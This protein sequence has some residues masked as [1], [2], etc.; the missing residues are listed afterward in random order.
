[1]KDTLHA[2]PRHPCQGS[3]HNTGRGSTCTDSA[4]PSGTRFPISSKGAHRAPC[5]CCVRA[6]RKVFCADF[7][8]LPSQVITVVCQP[9]DCSVS[10]QSK[11]SQNEST[12]A[13]FPSNNA[14]LLPKSAV[15]ALST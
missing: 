14:R 3:N 4:Y 13:M 5:V 8:G 11:H 10:Y 7:L 6:V 15:F 2:R 9:Q 1:M 12:Q